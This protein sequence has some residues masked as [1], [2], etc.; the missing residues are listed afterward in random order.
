KGCSLGVK[1]GQAQ[2]H[3]ENIGVFS[4][5]NNFQCLCDSTHSK[6]IP[7]KAIQ[8]V[9]LNQRGPHCQNVEIIATLRS[10]KPVCL[11]PSASWVWLTVKAILAYFNSLS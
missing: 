5:R 2:M 9:R 8:N 3:C 6:F 10:G 4:L 11:E 7:P 1:S